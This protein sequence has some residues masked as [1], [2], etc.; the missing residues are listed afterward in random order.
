M[1]IELILEI[2][3]NICKEFSI[4]YSTRDKTRLINF[5]S[6]E[7]EKKIGAENE[8]LFRENWINEVNLYSHKYGYS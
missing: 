5:V 6:I 4:Q 1:N 2:T 8:N 7:L 3:W